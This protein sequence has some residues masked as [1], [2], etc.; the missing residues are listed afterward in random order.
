MHFIKQYLI[1]N[2][3]ERIFAEAVL[4]FFT[5]T[6]A[7]SYDFDLRFTLREFLCE[8]V[9]YN[10]FCHWKCHFLSVIG[11]FIIRKYYPNPFSH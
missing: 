5:G 4:D 10:I 9:T 11:N 7:A 3:M 6:Q 2:I 1:S 8:L